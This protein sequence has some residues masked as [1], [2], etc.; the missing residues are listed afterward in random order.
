M[1]EADGVIIIYNPDAPSQDQQLLDWFEF[2]VKK[3][4]L[5][6]EQ[7]LIFAHRVN[8]TTE[9]FRPRMFYCHFIISILLFVLLLFILLSSFRVFVSMLNCVFT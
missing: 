1:H 6:E 5:K 3:N 9:R 2:F 4:S 7:C 8:P